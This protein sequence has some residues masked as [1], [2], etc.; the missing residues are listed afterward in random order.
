MGWRLI[1]DHAN[2]IEEV[3]VELIGDVL[4]AVLNA[5]EPGIDALVRLPDV[6]EVDVLLA[7]RLIGA[8]QVGLAARPGLVLEREGRPSALQP[9]IVHVLEDQVER[10]QAL[11]AI[12][13]LPLSV[14]SRLDHDR[15]QEVRLAAALVHIIE[16]PTNLG[17]S[18]P[19]PALIRRHEEGVLNIADQPRL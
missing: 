9:L 19:V 8:L 4:P 14:G 7:S 18:P 17:S 10:G 5:L 16:E 15:L 3:A 2:R 6:E 11:L 12:D 1:P 13:E